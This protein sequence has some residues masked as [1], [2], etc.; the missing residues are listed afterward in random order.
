[1]PLLTDVNRRMDPTH[2]AATETQAATRSSRNMTGKNN[3]GASQRGR[4]R[5]SLAA[6]F[7]KL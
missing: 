1:M 5:K 2:N 3:G 4:N 6:L 7:T